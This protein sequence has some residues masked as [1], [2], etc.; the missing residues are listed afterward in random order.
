MFF[1][2]NCLHISK[3]FYLLN[4]VDLSELTEEEK[5]F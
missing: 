1:L 2:H 5:N 4:K 3:Y